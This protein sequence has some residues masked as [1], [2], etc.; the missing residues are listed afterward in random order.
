[1]NNVRF[2]KKMRLVSLEIPEPG[3]TGYQNL[4]RQNPNLTRSRATRSALRPKCPQSQPMKPKQGSAFVEFTDFNER[5]YFRLADD[6]LATTNTDAIS[7][8][9]YMTESLQ[10]T[11]GMVIQFIFQ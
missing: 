10:E 2:Q 11:L 6:P 9:P 4:M 5:D 8:D 3:A 1:M 7:G